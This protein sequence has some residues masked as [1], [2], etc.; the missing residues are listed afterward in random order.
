MRN[1]KE[2]QLSLFDRDPV[3]DVLPADVMQAI[4]DARLEWLKRIH[5]NRKPRYIIFTDRDR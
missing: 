5:S 3:V 2:Q 1:N 4:V